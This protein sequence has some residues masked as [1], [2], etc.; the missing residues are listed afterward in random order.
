MK[1][2]LELGLKATPSPEGEVSIYTRGSDRASKA[3]L[4]RIGKLFRVRI[5][6]EAY[7]YRYTPEVY[8]Y[9]FTIVWLKADSQRYP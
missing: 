5:A 1:L 8:R 3:G 7:E 4:P 9:P 6:A 2:Q